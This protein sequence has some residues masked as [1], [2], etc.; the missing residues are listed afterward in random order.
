MGSTM[1]LWPWGRMYRDLA[2]PRSSAWDTACTW[3]SPRTAL[4]SSG[5][6]Q[7]SPTRALSTGKALPASPT[8]SRS[9][10]YGGAI[11]NHREAIPSNG[12][13]EYLSDHPGSDSPKQENFFPSRPLPFPYLL[14]CPWQMLT[15]Y[16]HKTWSGVLFLKTVSPHVILCLRV[17]TYDVVEKKRYRAGFCTQNQHWLQ[18][19][20]SLPQVCV[21]QKQVF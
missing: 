2:S 3:Q 16:D 5:P 6:S 12:S 8:R 18:N 19:A 11:Q 20:N 13:R 15:D 21:I 4:R 14:P 17:G 1:R 9:G 7:F 10:G